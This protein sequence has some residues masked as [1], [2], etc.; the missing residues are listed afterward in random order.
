M[1]KLTKIE[2][3]FISELISKIEQLKKVQAEIEGR[4]GTALDL[5]C[6]Q[7]NLK[8]EWQLNP[9]TGTLTKKETK[10]E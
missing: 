5:I 9:E 4:I 1:H 8:G 10:G 2:L 7:N 3:R 6:R